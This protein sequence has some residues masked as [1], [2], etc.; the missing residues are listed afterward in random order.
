MR[1]RKP[2]NLHCT[3]IEDGFVQYIH[4]AIIFKFINSS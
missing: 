2:K 1:V 3:D 4:D